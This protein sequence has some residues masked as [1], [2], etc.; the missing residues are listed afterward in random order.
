MDAIS[1]G[2]FGMATASHQLDTTAA[3]LANG[4]VDPATALVGVAQDKT[5][6]QA[7]AAVVKAADQMIGS[8][9]DMKV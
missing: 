3:S 9:L 4:T 7:N 1:S 2:Y 8:L 6:F 5:A